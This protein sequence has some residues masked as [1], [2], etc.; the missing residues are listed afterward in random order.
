MDPSQEFGFSSKK[1][2]DE[3]TY[4]PAHFMEPMT[5]RISLLDLNLNSS[6]NPSVAELVAALETGKPTVS[7]PLRIPGGF[8]LDSTHNILTM[9]HPGIPLE[10]EPAF[11][12]RNVALLLVSM[13][14]LSKRMT[15]G[16]PPYGVSVYLFDDREASEETTMFLIGVDL[17]KTPSDTDYFR[18]EVTLQEL[19]SSKGSLMQHE[20]VKVASS[21]WHVVV[22]ALEGEYEPSTTPVVVAGISMVV[23]CFS[24]SFWIWWD[25]KRNR[26]IQLIGRKAEAEKAAVKLHSA[27]DRARA[28][29]ELNDYIAHEIRNPLA[30]AMSACS[31]VK[32][33][34]NETPPMCEKESQ[35]S[36]REDVGIIDSSLTF[37]ND[38]LRSMLDMHKAES[39]KMDINL[40]PADLKRDILEPVAAML[41]Q[42][43]SNFTVEIDCPENLIVSTDKLRLKQVVINLGRNSSKFVERGFI[44]F[45]ATVV[46]H[47]IRIYVEDS[48]PGIPNE[49]RANLFNKF[50]D[51][52]DVL[53]QGTGMGLCLCKNLT[54]LLGGDIWL[55][56]SYDS[57]LFD[58][59]GSR[60]VIDTNSP[61]M[62]IE[63]CQEF[64]LST[65]AFEDEKKDTLRRLLRESGNLSHPLVAES[66]E[67]I[68][69][70]A[71]FSVL[72]VDD[73]MVLRKLF[74]RSVKKVVDT[75]DIK[76]AANGEAAIQMLKTRSFDLIFVDQY[77]SSAEK[78]LL[79]TETVRALRS[80]GVKSRICGLSA[81]DM[82]RQF[83]AAGA[84]FFLQKPFP[85]KSD[86]LRRALIR[87]GFSDRSSSYMSEEDKGSARIKVAAQCD[88]KSDTS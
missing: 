22:I 12:P 24:V 74:G 60:F 72:F 87:I 52:L 13:D 68:E 17:S 48:G 79:G 85:C 15:A 56:E 34:V 45:V 71:D 29:Q 73:D 1:S 63:E 61:P 43:D 31:F 6:S 2:P 82:E 62:S 14:M 84:D 11:L 81:N 28:E 64:L 75:W 66:K 36:V 88:E 7:L 20:L 18:P 65:E 25:S 9:Y 53:E 33:A 67:A 50:Q 46:H 38:L 86:E 37:I 49:K 70:P 10:S 3:A 77:M 8:G 42:R 69:L 19:L 83:L 16:I 44:R 35:D 30:A 78:T 55:D 57:G 21:Q 26:K 54:E 40:S 23:A 47:R 80:Q 59:P 76:E 51:S 39:M 41:Y 5:E 4:Y 27:Q 32:S 58:C